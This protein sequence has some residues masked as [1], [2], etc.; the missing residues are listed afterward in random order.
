V[1]DHSERNREGLE[2]LRRLTSLSD[3]ELAKVTGNGWNVAT[4]LGHMAF[5][6]RMLPLRWDTYEKDGVFAQL[7]P[8][9]F[10]LIN[11]AGA[12][13][14]SA[15]PPRAAV[16][17]CIEAAEG[18]VARIAAL[19]EKTVAVALETN[20]PALLDRGLHWNPHIDQIESAIGRDV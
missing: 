13:D 5:F 15:L 8:N 17:R 12:G 4:V 18:A 1:S 16:A 6:D 19:P 20:R 7:T 3:A 2:R 14:W 9:H 11:H 10:D